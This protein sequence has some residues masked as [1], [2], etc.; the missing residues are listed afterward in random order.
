MSYFQSTQ[1]AMRYP[2]PVPLNA[3]ELIPVTAE[4]TIPAGLAANDIIEMGCVP[5]GCIVEDFK[6]AFEKADTG[7]TIAFDAGLFSGSYGTADGTRTVGTDFL[8]NATSA[9]AGGIASLTNQA[10]RFIQP[11]ADVRG[12]GLKLRTAATT[13]VVG[14]RIRATLYVRPVPP[15]IAFA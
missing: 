2:H 6:A 14:A 4:F 1:M 12:W 5:E 9:Q 3:V 13:L 10:A 11:S 15:G 7:T 8:S